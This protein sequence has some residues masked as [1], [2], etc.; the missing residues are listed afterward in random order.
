MDHVYPLPALHFLLPHA[1]ILQ[2]TL[3]EEIQK[4]V[5]PAGMDQRWSLVNDQ[6][7]LVFSPSGVILGWTWFHLELKPK[8]FLDASSHHKDW[9][10]RT[11]FPSHRPP[12]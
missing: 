1:Q 9:L 5:R 8:E 11:Q 7:L 12:Q 2:P 3:I 10:N 4:A 6:L